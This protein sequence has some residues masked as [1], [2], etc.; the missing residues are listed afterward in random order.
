MCNWD[1]S[2]YHRRKHMQVSP[3]TRGPARCTLSMTGRELV[4]GLPPQ[5]ARQQHGDAQLTDSISKQEGR[6]GSDTADKR[7]LLFLPC[8]PQRNTIPRGFLTGYTRGP[9]TRDTQKGGTGGA[10]KGTGVTQCF[11]CK[12]LSGSPWQNGIRR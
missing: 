3:Q 6:E 5:H 8:L 10:S 12:D 9:R 4:P 2:H 7:G 1:N 11:R